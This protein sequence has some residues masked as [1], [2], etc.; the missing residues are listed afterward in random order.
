MFLHICENTFIIFFFYFCLFRDEKYYL[1]C[2]L[3]MRSIVLCMLKNLPHFTGEL[4]RIL[5]LLQDSRRWLLDLSN[6]THFSY[7]T[8]T[9]WAFMLDIRPMKS[10]SSTMKHQQSGWE[11]RHSRSQC[12]LSHAATRQACVMLEG[13]RVLRQA[14][15]EPSKGPQRHLS[16]VLSSRRQSGPREQR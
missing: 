2:I 4:D 10:Q 16:Q 14:G 15:G 6:P 13:A 12:A 11:D 3:L 9:C 5:P 7:L 1:T 8:N